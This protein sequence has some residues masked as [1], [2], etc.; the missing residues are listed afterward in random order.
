MTQPRK[1]PVPETSVTEFAEIVA[2]KDGS[3]APVVVGGHAV[4][5]WSEY[6][7]SKGVGKLATY[8]PFTSKDLDLVGR[9]GCL[10]GFTTHT[11]EH[12]PVPNPEA[13]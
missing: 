6:Y 4:N 9:P 12:F 8:M 10:T 3:E 13:L 5:L 7:L 1:S 11:R 2:P